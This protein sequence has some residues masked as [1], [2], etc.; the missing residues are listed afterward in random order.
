MEL[1]QEIQRFHQLAHAVSPS[2]TGVPGGSGGTGSSA[3]P[4]PT[5]LA[6]GGTP[7][8]PLAATVPPEL[9]EVIRKQVEAQLKFRH[10][11]GVEMELHWQP[12]QLLVQPRMP[13]VQGS[14]LAPAQPPPAAQLPQPLLAAPAGVIGPLPGPGLLPAVPAAPPAVVGGTCALGLSTH[15]ECTLDEMCWQAAQLADLHRQLG[16]SPPPSPA[17]HWLVG[18]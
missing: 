2:R 13:M 12:R 4:A 17:P 10:Q 6:I 18:V 8:T 3:L 14:A 7:A 5:L 15:G 9:S 1:G 11:V 16:M